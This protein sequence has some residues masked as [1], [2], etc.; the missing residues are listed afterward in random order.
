MVGMDM[1]YEGYNNCGWAKFICCE[2]EM[3]LKT[4]CNKYI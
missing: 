1:I 3:L 2:H 4:K